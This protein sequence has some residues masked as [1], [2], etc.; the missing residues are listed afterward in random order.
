MADQPQVKNE[1]QA[2]RH[3][4]NWCPLGAVIGLSGGIIAVLA[5]SMLTAISWL[6]ATGEGHSYARTL[7]TILLVMTIPL[8]VL[9]AH[10]LDLMERRKDTER[11]DRF[12]HEK[13]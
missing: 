7:G 2:G 3:G 9:G 6:T 8:L 5:G 1:Y 4:W 11:D 12:C 10:C 13:K